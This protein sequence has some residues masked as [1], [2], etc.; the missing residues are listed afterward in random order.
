M[1]CL[2]CNELMDR[3]DCYT[4]KIPSAL[5]ECSNCG[6][7]QLWIRGFDMQVL[8]EGV[9]DSFDFMNSK[10]KDIYDSKEIE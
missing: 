9:I 8:F 7:K 5:Y 4:E 1:R 3:E 2:T 10:W 6:R